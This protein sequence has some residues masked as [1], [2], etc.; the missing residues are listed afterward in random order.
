MVHRVD[1][2]QLLLEYAEQQPSVTIH[3]GQA[4]QSVDPKGTVELADGS[5]VSA[6]V[7]V[8][9]DG[10][11]SVALS[12]VDKVPAPEPAEQTM[13]R[14]LI[15]TAKARDDPR[16]RPAVDKWV[17]ANRLIAHTHFETSRQL[18]IYP[19]RDNELLNAAT[20]LPIAF[21]PRPDELED[22][23]NNPGMP[24]DVIEALRDFPEELRN[25]VTLAEDV[26]HWRSV[27]RDCPT[28]FAKDNLVLVG[29]AAH[30]MKPT[31][32]AGA[33]IGIEDAA[34]LGVLLSSQIRKEHV[35][36]ALA[37]YNTARYV[38]GV[39]VK[40]ASEPPEAARR[41]SVPADEKLRD[42]TGNETPK[43]VVGFILA[44]DPLARANQALRAINA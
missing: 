35:G 6:D 15:P 33:G 32:G 2:H 26:K 10:V 28:T 18:V 44:E 1:L 20:L 4:V 31:Y 29:D 24:E 5:R 17:Y 41:S 14:F 16:G 12:A 22:A 19:C 23:W 9:A 36:K 13:Y 42:L 27:N 21:D 11:H 40:Y 34:V 38:R 25:L 7:I 3:L 43:D 37:A 30:P 39:T 8:G